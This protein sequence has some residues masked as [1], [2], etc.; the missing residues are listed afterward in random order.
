MFKARIEGQI[1]YFKPVDGVS[2][3]HDKV[4]N[5]IVLNIRMLGKEEAEA[6]GVFDYAQEMI[7]CA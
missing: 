6:Y 4:G 2:F 5:K 1:M 3:S 7:G